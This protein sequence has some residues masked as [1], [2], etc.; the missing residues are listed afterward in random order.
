MVFIH[1][2]FMSTDTGDGKCI[3][4]GSVTDESSLLSEFS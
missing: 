1:T 3:L 4:E 2:Y